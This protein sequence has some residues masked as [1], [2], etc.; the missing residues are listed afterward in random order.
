MIYI[1]QLKKSFGKKTVLNNISLDIEEGKCTALI[2]KNGAGKSTL[3]DILIGHKHANSGTVE[4]KL[5]LI[6]SHNMCILFQTT[7]LPKL[8]KVKEL[9]HLYQQLYTNPMTFNEFQK[10]TQFSNLQ[11]EQYANKLSGGQ[12]RLLD[13]VLTLIG[14]PQ[15]LIL[16]EPTTSMDI[17]TREHFWNL[18]EQLKEDG[19]TILYT[20][21]Y[22]EE[23]ER[24]ADKVVYLEQGSIKINDTPHN[25][26]FSQ[27]NSII[28]IMT[29]TEEQY[30]ILSETYDI[31]ITNGNLKIQT[32]N[33]EAVITNLIKINVDLNQ[34][35]IYKKSLLE[36]MFSKEERVVQ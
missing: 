13:F 32:E 16:D 30:Q 15:F 14:K 21:H 9:Y 1:N 26:L 22:I 10:L 31:E 36:L 29:F 4:D 11:L 25:I 7:N 3:I 35:T 23:V 34:I 12:K 5:N 27:N 20:S 18:I 6:S 19:I 33:V 17:E 24:M 8:I 28:E 2:G